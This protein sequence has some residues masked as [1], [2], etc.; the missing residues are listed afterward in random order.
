M[1]SR[2]ITLSLCDCAIGEENIM[3]I[4][5]IAIVFEARRD[6]LWSVVC[7]LRVVGVFIEGVCST[8]Y[9]ELNEHIRR[10]KID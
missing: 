5:Q 2:C 4:N 7:L 10:W 8:T 3:P 6:C 9:C 1:S